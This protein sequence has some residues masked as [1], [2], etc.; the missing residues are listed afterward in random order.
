MPRLW[1]SRIQRQA[2]GYRYGGS[3]QG[4]TRNTCGTQD[5]GRCRAG[6]YS[7]GTRHQ[8]MQALQAQLRKVQIPDAAYAKAPAARQQQSPFVRPGSSCNGG[9][10]W[11][12]MASDTAGGAG[13]GAAASEEEY[14]YFLFTGSRTREYKVI[15]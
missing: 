5:D 7:L 3:R 6:E 10:R 15:S 12:T 9:C 11:E 8:E 1:D 14:A 2:N 13:E 4:S